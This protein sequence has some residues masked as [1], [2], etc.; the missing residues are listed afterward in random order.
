VI[1]SL[2]LTNGKSFALKVSFINIEY[3]YILI[4]MINYQ[5]YIKCKKR[6]I[7]TSGVG[8]FVSSFL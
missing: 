8:E 4:K 7:K 2:S 6:N 3:Y 5:N 1:Y